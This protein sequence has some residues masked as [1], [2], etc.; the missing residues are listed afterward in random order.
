[1]NSINGPISQAQESEKT[2]EQPCEVIATLKLETKGFAA[3][4]S[5]AISLAISPASH[6][7]KPIT[8]VQGNQSS[9]QS[10]NGNTKPNCYECKHRGG[11]PGSA[12][13]SCRH[14]AFSA[15][16]DDPLMMMFSLLGKRAGP[17]QI[18]SKDCEVTG[19]KHGVKMG[20]FNHPLNFDPVWLES[21]TGYETKQ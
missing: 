17:M 1:M 12:H 5:P 4:V 21:C 20:W 8:E 2:K 7:E 18:V 19:N 11:V 6:R 16:S 13:S 10:G 9:S 15:V 14:P 3:P